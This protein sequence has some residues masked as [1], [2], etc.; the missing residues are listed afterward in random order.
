MTNS[1]RQ[2]IIEAMAIEAY[3]HDGNTIFKD[4]GGAQVPWS[5]A[6]ASVKL[7]YI[8]REEAALKALEQWIDIVPCSPSGVVRMN[9]QGRTI[10]SQEPREGD[11]SDQGFFYDKRD[12]GRKEVYSAID[13]YYH[14]EFGTYSDNTTARRN[15][16]PALIIRSDSL[17]SNE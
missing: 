11:M 3:E 7:R 1:T 8:K 15:N 16:K 17:E 13:L 2:E 10:E 12:G 9:E 6:G 14:D 4:K 5:L